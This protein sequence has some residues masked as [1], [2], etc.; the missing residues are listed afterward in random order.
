MTLRKTKRITI[1]DRGKK[2]EMSAPVTRLCDQN[3]HDPLHKTIIFRYI[4][5]IIPM[6]KYLMKYKI[7]NQLPDCTMCTH[8]KYT[9]EHI[10]SK[11]LAFAQERKEMQ[12]KIRSLVPHYSFNN[13]AFCL[14]GVNPNITTNNAK[15]D[16]QITRTFHEYVLRVWMKLEKVRVM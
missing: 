6:G 5:G 4:Y 10:F 9:K 15:L 8:G 12:D 3:L 11:C 13:L 2:T 7:V 1:V 16:T 14:F